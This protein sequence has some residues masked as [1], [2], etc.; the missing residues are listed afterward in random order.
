IRVCLVKVRSDEHFLFLDIHHIVSDLGSMN[1]LVND[2]ISY[3]NDITL[4]ALDLQYKDYAVWQHSPA[5]QKVLNLH[6]DFWLSEF[7]EESYPLELPTSFKRPLIK[8]YEGGALSFVL[9]EEM[10]NGLRDLSNNLGIT[11]FMNLFAIYNI[12]LSKLANTDDIV[13]GTP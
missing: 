11:F 10:T 13:I 4:P 12:L 1:I 7:A 3:Y 2:L 9:D 5:Q 6:K 8:S